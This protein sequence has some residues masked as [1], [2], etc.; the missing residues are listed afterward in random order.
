MLDLEK[1]RHNKNV[2]I[3]HADKN[4]GPVGVNANQYIW[5]V[6]QEH[7]LDPTTYQLVSE[8]EAKTAANKLYIIYQ[9][10][11]K[12]SLCDN[13]TK[14]SKKYIRQKIR[15]ATS[16]PFGFGYFYPTIKIHKSHIND[17]QKCQL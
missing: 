8:E 3:T 15:N 5:W 4:L 1:I 9:W 14:D 11:Q 10:M 13:L 17:T 12:N 16:T 7:L 6:L 2:I